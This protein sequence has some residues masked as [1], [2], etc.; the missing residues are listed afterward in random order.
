MNRPFKTYNG[1][2]NGSGVYQSI[3]NQIPPH[4]IFVSAFAG[5]CGVLANKKPAPMANIA[6]DLDATVITAWNKIP[7]CIGV[8]ADAIDW[9]S[10]CY[11]STRADTSQI[12]VF[13]DPPY[14]KSVRSHQA[15]LY[16]HEMTDP[17]SHKNMLGAMAQW[18]CKILISHYPCQ[19][20]DDALQTWRTIDIKGRTRHGMRTER[21]Y[22]N[23]PEP[24]QLHDYSFIG[25]D[26][27]EREQYKKMQVNMVNKFKRMTLQER[28]FIIHSLQQK[29]L[30]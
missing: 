8:N 19:L 17:Q 20:Y 30:L 4:D 28:Y 13:A 21:L 5:N 16:N 11:L 12:F 24:S 15:N 29:Q 1:G 3:I 9:L 26:F 22:M 23:Y 25:N 6:I 2:K 27:R 14:L 18:K 7:G 10:D